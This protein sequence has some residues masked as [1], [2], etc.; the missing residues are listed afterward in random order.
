MDINLIKTS[1]LFKNLGEAQ[2]EEVLNILDSRITA[3]KK[4][5]CIHRQYT[6]MQK[7]G[8]VL[9]GVVQVCMDDVDGNKMIM[10]QVVPG[11]TF[12]ESLCFLNIKESPV[13]IY[14]SESCEILWLSVKNLFSGNGDE[15]TNELEK[16]FAKM[17][18]ER[19]LS[20]NDRIQVLSKVKLRDK[21]MTYFSQLSQKNGSLTFNLP[22]NRDD[23]ASYIGTNRSALSRELSEMKKAGIIDYHKNTVKIIR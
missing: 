6:Q 11:Q 3:Y 18:G 16:R 20:M 17:L 21:L 7:F 10:A 8:F 2:T 22:G 5:D 4:N 15:I 12:G 9:S 1:V 23:L 19:T 14:A 13:Y